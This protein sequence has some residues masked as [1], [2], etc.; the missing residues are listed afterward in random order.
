MN[1]K[2]ESMSR[3]GLR[4]DLGICHQTKGWV[5]RQGIKC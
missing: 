4:P 1:I 3:P 2:I 5:D